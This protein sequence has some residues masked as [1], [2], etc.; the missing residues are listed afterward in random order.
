MLK[1]KWINWSSFV[2]F[3]LLRESNRILA[4]VL[5]PNVIEGWKVRAVIYSS[6]SNLL[7]DA[8]QTH[9]RYS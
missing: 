5:Y 8:R 4:S 2:P 1:N 6:T 7:K 3:K 9:M